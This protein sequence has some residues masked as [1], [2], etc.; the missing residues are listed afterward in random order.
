META[1]LTN[2]DIPLVT[3]IL[4]GTAMSSIFHTRSQST[5][6]REPAS[7]IGLQSGRE[8]KDAIRLYP[9]WRI[10]SRGWGSLSNSFWCGRF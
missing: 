6:G 5:A 9:S 8:K 1:V 7:S 2:K 3:Q 10:E 4:W